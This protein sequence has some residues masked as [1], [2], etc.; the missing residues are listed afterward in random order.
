MVQEVLAATLNLFA[1]HGYARLSIEA[2]A[3]RAGVNKTTVYRRWPSKSEL[4]AAAFM[5]LRDDDPEPP[6][7]GSLGED[8]LQILRR[9]A[10]QM[11]TPTRRAI[12]QA[13]LLENADPE[14]QAIIKRMREERPAIPAIVFTRALRRGEL[15]KGSDPQLIAAALLGPLHTR[16]H[17]KRELVDDAFVRGLVRLIVAGATAGGARPG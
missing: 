3:L 8:L 13:L 17:V 6:D 1:E 4:L 12:M 16:V 9:L 15:P 7:S 14:L 11:A 2:V 5:T 10:A